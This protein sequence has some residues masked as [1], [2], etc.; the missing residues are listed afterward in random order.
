MFT[1][2]LLDFIVATIIL[3]IVLSDFYKGFVMI[4]RDEAPLLFIAQVSIWIVKVFPSQKRDERYETAI[5]VYKKRKRLYGIF[6][7]FGG[8]W[9]IL[10]SILIMSN[11]LRLMGINI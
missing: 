10:L 11:S 9:G 3:I 8:L 5:R 1:K 7:I 6:A 2:G 4:F